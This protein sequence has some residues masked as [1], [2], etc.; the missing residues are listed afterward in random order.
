MSFPHWGAIAW[1]DA[2]TWGLL[3]GAGITAWCARRAF[4]KQS[5]ELTAFKTEVQ[6]GQTLIG[7]QS[8][9]IKIQSG[10]LE[11]QCKLTTEQ[12]GVLELQR[13]DL[14]ESLDQRKRDAEE[15]G[16]AQAAMVTTWFG[17]REITITEW[18][19][20][21]ITRPVGTVW[22]AFHPERVRSAGLPGAG[23]LP[24]RPGG[25]RRRLDFERARRAGRAGPCHCA[26]R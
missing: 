8:E 3:I 18:A 15:R 6:H 4:G 14:E 17:C 7:Q 5:E 9:L 22:G 24:L 12:I 10:Q 1:G 20:Q 2:P 23:I 21:Q 11:E 16:S 26:G 19:G 13:K 25:G